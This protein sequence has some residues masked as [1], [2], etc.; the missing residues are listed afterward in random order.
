MDSQRF[1]VLN[2]ISLETK[3]FCSFCHCRNIGEILVMIKNYSREK[4]KLIH[5]VKLNSSG[6]AWYEQKNQLK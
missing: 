3:Y 4:Y 6:A 1:T 2:Y 5:K